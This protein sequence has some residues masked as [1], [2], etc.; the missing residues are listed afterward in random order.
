[1]LMGVIVFFDDYA[2]TLI[3]GSTMRPLSDEMKISREKLSYIVDSTAA[4]VAGMALISTWI[5][6]E[7]GLIN[8]AFELLGIDVNEYEYFLRSI[9]YR[10]YGLFALVMVFATGYMSKDFWPMYRAEK[11]ARVMGKVIG[12]GAK[13]M[14]FSDMDV[15]R[16]ADKSKPR[17]VNAV[18]PVLTLVSVSFWGLW[19]SGRIQR[20]CVDIAIAW[21]N[22][23]I[24][25]SKV[26]W[27][28]C[29]GVKCFPHFFK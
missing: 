9:P 25:S 1:M 29:L 8:E 19:Y 26:F 27:Q 23:D 17:V 12:D 24:C 13:P 21:S 22:C 14:S 16:T 4:P 20:A 18:M 5:G 6:Y 28:E 3:V 7:L 11:R 2:N 15:K 10:F